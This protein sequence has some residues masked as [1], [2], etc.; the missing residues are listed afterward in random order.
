MIKPIFTIVVITKDNHDELMETIN[1]I[2]SSDLYLI[3]LIVIDSSAKITTLNPKVFNFIYKHT[4]PNG[5]YKAQNLGISFAKGDF[6]IVMNSGDGFTP[7]ANKILASILKLE[8]YNAFALSQIFRKQSG[9]VLSTYI[10]TFNSLWPHQSV[11][12]RKSI[13]D[14]YGYYPEDCLYTA[15]QIYFAK[16]RKHLKVY[17]SK[18]IL[19]YFTDG[20]V[21]TASFSLEIFKENFHLWRQLNRGLIFSFSKSFIFPIVK[22]I[23]EN[24]LKLYWLGFRLRRLYDSNVIKN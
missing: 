11:V 20:G 16:I 15:E 19:S 4:K 6:V 2:P 9:E 5:I 14:E 8:G 1:T 17:Y 21:S 23:L 7:N 24:K 3:E 22:Y 10:P 13:Y 12:L 18:E